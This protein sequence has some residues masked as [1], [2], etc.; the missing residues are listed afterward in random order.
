MPG[1]RTYR[2]SNKLHVTDKKVQRLRQTAEQTIETVPNS[3][4]RISCPS[5]NQENHQ[6]ELN[7]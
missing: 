5:T 2:R 7:D 3:L 4:H 6:K 1:Q